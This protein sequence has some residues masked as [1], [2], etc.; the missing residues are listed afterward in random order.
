[1]DLV[2]SDTQFG[3]RW[4]CPWPTCT[5]VCWGDQPT[6]RPADAETREARHEAHLAFDPIWQTGRVSRYKLYGMLAEH[7]GLKRKK[8]HIGFFDL[9]TCRRVI[10]WCAEIKKDL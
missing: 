5:V 9:E 2:P 3:K 1:M 10:A 4:A 7:L 8:T 6:S